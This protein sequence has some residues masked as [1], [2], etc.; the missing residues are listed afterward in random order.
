MNNPS[1][2]SQMRER[3]RRFQERK[4]QE[5][6]NRTYHGISLRSIIRNIAKLSREEQEKAYEELKD[7]FKEARRAELRQDQFWKII[8]EEQDR[9]RERN[10]IDLTGD[11]EP[12]TKQRKIT[13][14]MQRIPFVDD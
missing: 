14:F 3:R 2:V 11:D 12:P 8:K 13:D 5:R 1:M 9:I 4:R 7:D 6:L 10:T